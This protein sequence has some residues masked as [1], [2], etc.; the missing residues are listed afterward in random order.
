[1]KRKQV[2]T[3][4]VDE[5]GNQVYRPDSTLLNADWMKAMELEEQDD[6][7]AAQKLEEMEDTNMVRYIEE[8]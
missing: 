5:N 3:I 4:D 8:Q 2:N 7:K 1:M 6:K